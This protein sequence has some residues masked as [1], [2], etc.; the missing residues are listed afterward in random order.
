MIHFRTTIIV[1]ACTI[2]IP[3]SRVKKFLCNAFVGLVI[4]FCGALGQED[5]RLVS[6]GIHVFYP[7][8]KLNT[9]RVCTMTTVHAC[10]MFVVYAGT[11]TYYMD[12]L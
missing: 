5:A 7:C 12:V 6:Y 10:I 4:V 9:I 1:Y 8:A 2:F 11:M 3:S